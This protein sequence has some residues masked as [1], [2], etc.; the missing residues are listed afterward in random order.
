[1]PSNI[2]YQPVPLAEEDIQEMRREAR[3]IDEDEEERGATG[4]ASASS[5]DASGQLEGGSLNPG[6][7]SRNSSDDLP[8]PKLDMSAPPPYE[9]EEQEESRRIRNGEVDPSLLILPPGEAGEVQPPSYEEVQRLKAQEASGEYVPHYQEDAPGSQGGLRVLRISS[10]GLDPETAE[11]AE[12]QL[13]GT[14][15]MFFIA[16]GAAFVF[17]WIGFIMLLCFCHTVAGRTGA[18]AGFGLSLAK[19]AVIVK[20]STDLVSDSNTWLLWLIMAL[21]LLI[22]MRAILQY[23]Y[24][25]REWHQLPQNSR[26]RFFLFY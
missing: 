19:W 1:M 26:Q 4:G 23:L 20:H 24:A 2:R 15:F 6:F 16:F 13:L 5:I 25:K 21:G 9:E 7:S 17:N 12:E 22:C 18:L 14:D 3:A 11:I 10:L 8:P